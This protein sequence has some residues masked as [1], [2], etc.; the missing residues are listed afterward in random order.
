MADAELWPALPL[1]TWQDTYTT[2]HLWTQIVGKTRLALAPSENHW[3]QV[4]LYVTARGLTTS[5]IPSGERTFTVDF[6]FIDHRLKVATSDGA[7]RT[8]ALTAQTVAEFYSSYRET[9]GALGITAASWPV[10]VEMATVIPFAADRQHASYDAGAASR[11]WRV[12][13]QADR[14]LKRFRGRFLGKASPVH[15]FWGSFDLATTRF[16]GRPAP[17]H[18]G[19]VPNCPDYVM[20][21]AYSHE[22]SS[23]GFWP[24]GG[25]IAEPAFYAYAYPEPP[26]Y[27]DHAVRPAAA[28]YDPQAREFIL[29]YDAVR[30]ASAPE[31][32][33]S[34]SCKRPM[35]R[36]PISA[37]GTAPLSTG[38]GGVGAKLKTPRSRPPFA[39]RHRCEGHEI[40][41][42]AEPRHVERAIEERAREHGSERGGKG[43][44]HGRAGADRRV[45]RRRAPRA[46]PRTAPP[47]RA[48]RPRRT[49]SGTGSRCA[50]PCGRRRSR[51]SARGPAGN[52]RSQEARARRDR[53][54]RCRRAGMRPGIE[55][56]EGEL[57]RPVQ[58]AE[59]QHAQHARGRDRA[60]KAPPRAVGRRLDIDID[61]VRR[62]KQHLLAQRGYR[63]AAIGRAQRE[64]EA[65][66][67][68]GASATFCPR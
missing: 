47:S 29:P 7:I 1:E 30:T 61:A 15:F 4:P 58:H 13:V 22:C 41:Q 45:Q 46:R 28:R 51:T 23:C 52:C 18:R 31:T 24:G 65:V 68:S 57:E 60:G 25:A 33:C 11:C 43:R 38:R 42:R 26:G 40:E 53:R 48:H 5:A 34:N 21:E 27:R 39:Q 12:L 44:R 66:A 37:A 56:G 9:L 14:V 2:L 62:I 17:R 36:R 10:P 8:N 3:W 63:W 67:R 54:A 32:T 16:S 19:G 20:V 55:Q 50:T 49:S 64:R 6:D 35:T 59:P